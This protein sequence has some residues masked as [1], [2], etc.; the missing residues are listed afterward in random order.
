MI[1]AVAFIV[2]LG[3]LVWAH[4]LGH[5]V[6]A[7]LVGMRVEEFAFGF[8]PRLLTLFRRKGTE[9]TVHAFPLGGFVKI[10]GMEPGQE[11]VEDGY[12]AQAAWKRALVVFSGPLMSFVTGAGL[13]IF[14]GVYWGFPDFTRS[15]NQVG[16]VNPQT[17][18]ARIDLRAGD[19]ILRI[20]GVP[21]AE[22]RQMIDFIHRRPGQ[23]VTLV[24][25][26][27]GRVMEKTAVPQWNIHFAGAAWSFMN[28][29]RASV[30][31]DWSSAEIT[32]LGLRHGD[33]LLRINGQDIR[34]GEAMVKAIAAADGGP[35]RLTILRGGKALDLEIKPPIRWVRFPEQVTWVFP[36]AYVDPRSSRAEKDAA[37]LG[38]RVGDT[39]LKIN[40]ARI[41]RGEDLIAAVRAASGRQM[42]FAVLRDEDIV[43]V[44][45]P[46]PAGAPQAGYFEAIGLL[47]F[48]PAPSLEKT[49][50][51]ESIKQGVMIT[52]GM[53]SQ[54]VQVF[55]SKRRISEEV[56]GPVLIAKAT[57]ASVALGP[58]YYLMQVAALSLSLAF[59]N[60]LPIPILDG[61]HLLILAIERA[62]RK[63]LTPQQMAAVQTVGLAIILM[64]V[65]TVFY[66]DI[67]KIA[68]GKVPQ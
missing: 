38:F 21:I 2:M 17:E 9:Y 23:R 28:A 31:E 54:F 34:G 68:T 16:S 40:G 12:Q 57:A 10:A 42:R 60:L 62:R 30:N 48:S 65:V 29:N 33:V 39:L 43:N 56:G 22:G 37:A 61:G 26:R 66:A 49:S 25:Q 52:A 45:L 55:S 19:R 41:S 1:T 46:A 4:E 47:G 14:L 59:V 11:D 7:R 50:L 44:R 63:R 18:A 64:L 32:R 51:G 67:L 15:L 35:A 58:Y 6:V 36:G 13:F 3:V 5:F 20:N 53:A 27:N 8:G 24:V